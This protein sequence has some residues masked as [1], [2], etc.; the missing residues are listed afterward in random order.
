M[1]KIIPLLP[2]LIISNWI[3]D[4][5]VPQANYIILKE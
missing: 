2:D 5:N 4:D 1:L 3:E